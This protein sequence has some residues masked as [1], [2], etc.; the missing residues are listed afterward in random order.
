MTAAAGPSP[1]ARHSWPFTITR[2]VRTGFTI[3]VAP[4]F[5]V[6][7]D[8]HHLLADVAGGEVSQEHVYLREYRDRG[9]VRLWLLYRV[10][11]LTKE[12][13]GGDEGFDAQNR[14]TPLIEGVVCRTRP[15]F[16]VTDELFTRV[17][18]LCGPTVWAFYTKDSESFPVKPAP[19]F[20]APTSGYVLRIVQQDPYVSERNL[21]V[22]LRGHHSR[23]LP[24]PAPAGRAPATAVGP[25]G[26]GRPGGTGGRG[27]DGLR[28]GEG[29]E[30]GGRGTDA[31]PRRDGGSVVGGSGTT[32]GGRTAGPARTI[33]VSIVVTGLLVL[34]LLLVGAF[35]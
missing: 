18:E 17:H 2:A 28:D 10:V 29:G 11:Y 23:P 33:L 7:A 19:P 4:D 14:R 16:D 8:R 22:A 30:I 25:A 35:G 31:V 13:V 5:L 34:L 3:V 12:D 20:G 26:L 24:G 15:D 9:S 32:G 1:A 6:D 27:A 21:Q